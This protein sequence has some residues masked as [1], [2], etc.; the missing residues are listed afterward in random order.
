MDRKKLKQQERNM[1]YNHDNLKGPAY[2]LLQIRCRRG[3]NRVLLSPYQCGGKQAINGYTHQNFMRNMG[4][5]P[6]SKKK[7]SKNVS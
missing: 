6:P 3:L 5:W 4:W 2:G 7:E 1:S